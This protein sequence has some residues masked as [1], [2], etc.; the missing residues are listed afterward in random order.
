MRENLPNNNTQ[1]ALSVFA[2]EVD[3]RKRL[4]TTLKAS[5]R[6]RGEFDSE[7]WKYN[8]RVIQFRT[9]RNPK[10]PEKQG[11]LVDFAASL[12]RCV[13]VL[14]M[15]QGLT[16]E[17]VYSKIY[18]V[19]LLSQRLGMSVESWLQLNR[20]SLNKA[21]SSL[22]DVLNQTTI[23]HRANE[24]GGLI[25]YLNSISHVNSGTKCYFMPRRLSWKSGVK[26]P[27]RSMLDRTSEAATAHSSEKFVPSLHIGL[28]EARSRIRLNPHLEP[29]SGYDRIRLEALAFA[30]SLGLRVGEICTLPATALDHDEET[31]SA[32]VRAFTEKGALPSARPLSSLW[33]PLVTEAND[34]L[35]NQCSE[36]RARAREIEING[37]SFVGDVLAKRRKNA[38][39][40]KSKIA[41]L[42]LA[43]LD[44]DKHYF[45]NEIEDAFDLSSKEFTSGG[46]YE[47]SMKALPRIVA[48][49]VSLWLDD[50][51]RR[52]DWENYAKHGTDHR[53]G[54][55]GPKYLSMVAIADFCGASR[56]SV[57]KAS[58]C[59]GDIRRLLIDLSKHGIFD[60]DW[61]VTEKTK[62]FFRNKWSRLRRQVL[63]RSGGGQCCVVDIDHWCEL[64]SRRYKAQL[65]RHFREIYEDEAAPSG[66]PAAFRIE[67][68]S[69]RA[70]PKLSE[71][72]IVVWEYQFSGVRNRGILP[73]P[74]LRSDFYNYLCSNS[75]KRTV[76]ERL[77]I[78]DAQ[79]HI[80]SITPHQIRHWVTTALLRSGPSEMMA[81]LWMGRKPGVSRHY[82]HRTAKERAE[83]AR[84]KYLAEVVPDDFLGRKI[85]VWRT[86]GLSQDAIRQLVVS[87]LRVMH[88]VPWGACSRELYI[89][90][91][92]RGLMCLRGFGSD[93]ACEFFHIDRTSPEARCEIEKLRD[94]YIAMLQTVEPLLTDARDA[95]M[96]E[97]NEAEPLDQHIRFIVDVIRGCEEALAAYEKGVSRVSGARDA[98]V[99][100]GVSAK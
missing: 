54:Q 2:N 48:A 76:F 61:A 16:Y 93:T 85:T 1:T 18:A 17:S 34:Y 15:Q 79:G 43:G 7:K 58:W 91:C 9:L 83:L 96:N 56:S 87:K 49:H 60:E 94:K 42:T 24:I 27:I 36:A 62:D 29:K 22:P 6:V 59:Y 99:Q 100:H 30:I 67:R 44:E 46:K 70:A 53:T 39:L 73:K 72:L 98:V 64:L 41:Q 52:W 68:E 88:F 19:R 25:Q 8:G 21:V 3:L 95:I 63:A 80:F 13:A 77:N 86:S 12:A 5:G 51:F 74:I 55:V 20:S 81:D 57:P 11:L 10:G 89:S 40:S 78:R 97:L 33:T 35:L 65:E 26:N 45:V 37:F 32:F 69:S 38:P 28:G 90:P 92:T 4:F 82:D 31:G 75:G 50:R 71:H 47:S 66:S 84:A 23:Y 14:A